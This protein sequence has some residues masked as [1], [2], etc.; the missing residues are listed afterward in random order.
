MILT[1]DNSA[2]MAVHVIDAFEQLPK[3]VRH[4]ACH[5]WNVSVLVS[6]SYRYINQVGLFT[7]KV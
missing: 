4:V 2:P 5:G 7:L 1:F 3:I 6:L